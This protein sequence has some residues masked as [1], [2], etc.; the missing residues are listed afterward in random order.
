MTRTLPKGAMS[1]I[2]GVELT[3]LLPSW[4]R[5]LRAEN[6]SPRTVQNYQEA[7]SLFVAFLQATGLPTAPAEL[8]RGHIESWFEHLLRSFSPGT[9]ANRFRSLQQLFRWLE[10]EGEVA[11][12]P[13]HRMKA[14]AVPEEPVAVLSDTA[15]KA[16]LSTCS[17]PGFYDRRDTAV[18][19][20][21]VDTGVRLA[22]LTGLEYAPGDPDGALDLDLGQVRVMGKGR[23]PR[24]VPIGPRTVKALDRYLR[25]R[26]HH[27]LAD[28]PW[29]WLGKRGR[30]GETGV[31]QMLHRRAAEAGLGHVHPHQFRHTLAHWWK[32]SG[33][34]EEDLMRI[35]GWRSAD[36]LRRYGASAADTRAHQAHRRLRPGDRL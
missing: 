23:R 2:L 7:A 3:A 4:S 6:K 20:L 28:G 12:S 9:A 36:M 16:L 17:G 30:F 29:L 18:I 8:R 11:V 32:V 27:P 31:A 33:G 21:F 35:A 5:H 15:V 25:V 26:A 34:S 1:P 24:V 14:P 13:M 22:E 19:R 10:D